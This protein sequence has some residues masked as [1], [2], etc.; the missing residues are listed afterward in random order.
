MHGSKRPTKAEAKRMQRIVEIGC[1]ACMKVPF[2]T[3]MIGEVHHL[4][5]VGRRRGHAFTICLCGWHHRGAVPSDN[6]Q[7]LM[8]YLHG[9][10]LANGTRTFREEFGTDDELLQFQNQLLEGK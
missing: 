8:T 4:L 2:G 6:P 5:D 3:A 7:K 9:C 1:I 10:S